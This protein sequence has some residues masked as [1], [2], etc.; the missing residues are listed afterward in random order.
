MNFENYKMKED[1]PRKIDFTTKHY[2]KNGVLVA[3]KVGSS[4]ADFTFQRERV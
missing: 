2:Y 4:C 1:A 3:T